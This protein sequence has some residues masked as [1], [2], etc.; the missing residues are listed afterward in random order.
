FGLKAARWLGLATRRADAL[1]D[2]RERV[3]FVQLGGAAGTLA[4]VGD[5]GE[6]VTRYLAEELGLAVPDLPWHAERDRVAEIA[7][8]LGV[9]AGSMSKIAGDV[10]LLAQT[11]VGEVAEATAP[12][13]GGSSAMPQKRNPVDATLGAAAA[14]LAIGQVPVVLSAMSQEHE[15]GAGGWQAEWSSVPDLFRFTAGS[16]K[17]VRATIAGLQVDPARMRANLNQ[18][19]GLP[20]AESLTMALA[21]VL[22]RPE[23]YRLVQEAVREADQSG[24]AFH[25]AVLHHGQLRAA[26]SEEEIE[27]ALDPASYLGSAELFVERALAGYRVLQARVTSS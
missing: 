7:A 26:L 17:H 15:R 14:R 19:E 8:A 11:E 22:G 18:Q 25:E 1:L 6:R 27:R 12:G 21:R 9:V 2:L 5:E 3:L 20:L 4:S 10:L 16:V 23:A 13:K 24:V